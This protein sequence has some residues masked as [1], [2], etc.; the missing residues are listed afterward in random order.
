MSS[1]QITPDK[2]DAYLSTLLGTTQGGSTVDIDP[3]TARVVADFMEMAS[4]SPIRPE[5]ADELERQLTGQAHYEVSPE[6]RSAGPYTHRQTLAGVPKA[7]RQPSAPAGAQRNSDR[8]S[9]SERRGNLRALE[10]ARPG[11]TTRIMG[12]WVFG[13]AGVA[14]LLGLFLGMASLLQ[15][16]LQ[17]NNAG[18]EGT[19]TPSAAI[20]SPSGLTP[21]QAPVTYEPTSPF[22]SAMQPITVV[23]A[24]LATGATGMSSRLAWSPDGQSLA[25]ISLTN[26]ITIWERNTGRWQRY[27][28]TG[29]QEV[30]E[31]MA[32]SP[33]GR[34]LAAAFNGKDGRGFITLWDTLNGR[35]LNSITSPNGWVQSI[36][37]SPDGKRLAWTDGWQIAMWDPRSGNEL[38]KP[39]PTWPAPLATPTYGGGGVGTLVWSADGSMLASRQ[40]QVV[41]LWDP[42][43]GKEVARLLPPGT[44]MRMLWLGGE[45]VTASSDATNTTSTVAAW[46]VA[47]KQQIRSVQ[48]EGLVNGLSAQQ[49]QRVLALSRGYSN[50]G[51]GG[52]RLYDLGTGKLQRELQASA[53]DL[54]WSPDGKVLGVADA[55]AGV[56][57]L[58]APLEGQQVPVTPTYEIPLQQERSNCIAG[59]EILSVPDLSQREPQ[60][61]DSFGSV[62]AFSVDNVIALG[63]SS[64][65]S[66]PGN[67]TVLMRW[68][69]KAWADL[70]DPF[71][72]TQ[73][74]YHSVASLAPGPNGHVWVAGVYGQA[75]G[76][77]WT[78]AVAEWDGSHW[79]ETDV[80]PEG[81][82]SNYNL[83][84]ISVRSR[85]DA[86]IVGTYNPRD[87]QTMDQPLALHWDGN[88]WRDS[89]APPV[90]EMAQLNAVVD[91]G[92][93]NAWV[94]GNYYPNAVG[95]TPG[96]PLIMRW[97][98]REWSVVQG[99]TVG[100]GVLQ[101]I[102]GTAPD[103]VWAVGFQW[104]REAEAALVE[105]WD[106]KAWSKVAL[107]TLPGNSHHLFGVAAVSR[108]DVWAVG[109]VVLH[110][111]GREWREVASPNPSTLSSGS[112]NVA[113]TQVYTLL[114]SISVSPD[115]TVWAVG[116]DVD[117]RFFAMRYGPAVKCPAMSEAGAQAPICP[118]NWGDSP[119]PAVRDACARDK[120]TR[121]VRE[122]ISRAQTA[123]ALP[124]SV[125]P[126]YTPEPTYTPEVLLPQPESSKMV[127][128]L[129]PDDVM[130]NSILHCVTRGANS[131]WL[132]G[133][134]PNNGYTE[135]SPLYVL[136]RPGNG[137]ASFSCGE[138]AEVVVNTNPTLETF[139]RIATEG[140]E[141]YSKIWTCPRTL[142][143][144]EITSIN[145][146]G[147]PGLYADGSR[148]PGLNSVIHFRSQTGVT[149]TFD[150]A[151][152]NWSFD[153]THQSIATTPPSTPASP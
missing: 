127:R 49:S 7:N 148:F 134:V 60:Q 26:T 118:P 34:T 94:V 48:V 17:I 43:S 72:N 126:A 98:G 80:N 14:L 16:R 57:T 135:W 63:Q 104:S 53:T 139:V 89:H 143:T 27:I 83:T 112:Q 36:A 44:V 113:P 117:N 122:E 8:R 30:A 77:S 141:R 103:D 84:A 96:E 85:D 145:D 90:G 87:G 20:P 45:I 82:G 124:T 146:S 137:L 129:G 100:S 110:W 61:S 52:V 73:S 51:T 133:S 41:R 102:G 81:K 54:A 29:Y 71:G 74:G 121:T 28:E 50:E 62:V 67:Q 9:S 56:I 152:Q 109:D 68:N 40:A 23:R 128:P 95:E 101:A 19:P 150:M 142:K 149:G 108:E 13:L 25:S 86:W 22:I 76:S 99:P 32:W 153:D 125:L 59:W 97:N 115:G 5:F 123:Q 4:A 69:G 35:T 107:P 91:L 130:G 6:S 136:T 10:P 15:H 2:L 42:G 55:S 120:A 132:D 116:A 65:T 21:T 105:H 70:P 140:R 18:G 38:P 24:S 79:V 78:P 92:P 75:E 39:Q 93:D 119:D 144:L 58:W 37:W 31:S 114:R 111:D 47:T 66:R 88:A 64:G 138:G 33:D 147:K 1:D 11:P 46:D 12:R 151:T 106:G 131:H 3:E